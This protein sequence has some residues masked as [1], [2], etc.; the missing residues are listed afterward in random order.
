MPPYMLSSAGESMV[1]AE[2]P[3]SGNWYSP[4]AAVADPPASTA[5]VTS[6]TVE[7]SM[8][9]K[10][11]GSCLDTG[12]TLDRVGRCSGIIPACTAVYVNTL[13]SRVGQACWTIGGRVG[14]CA[15]QTWKTPAAA[16][17]VLSCPQRCEVTRGARADLYIRHVR[18]LC[19]GQEPAQAE[20]PGL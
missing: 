10:R 7:R 17:I 15:A 14:S 4:S 18:L 2:E 3:M 13:L 8:E 19:C 6:A 9:R 12:A 11:W 20:G 16:H 1:A 5:A